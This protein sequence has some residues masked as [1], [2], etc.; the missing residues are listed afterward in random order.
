MR[1]VYLSV[2][3]LHH[4]NSVGDVNAPPLLVHRSVVP[5]A[6]RDQILEL[7]WTAVRPVND[8]VAVGPRRRSVAPREATPLIAEME[9]GADVCRDRARCPPH[10]QW[11]RTRAGHPDRSIGRRCNRHHRPHGIAGDP[12]CGLG[13]DRTNTVQRCRMCS[14]VRVQPLCIPRVRPQRVRAHRH[15]EMRPLPVHIAVITATQLGGGHVNQRIGTA[16]R[17]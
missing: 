13:M 16:L 9:R 12:A 4:G 1:D 6:Q 10:R 3:R 11:H 8:V 7:R 14:A 17:P 2:R 15:R 5:P